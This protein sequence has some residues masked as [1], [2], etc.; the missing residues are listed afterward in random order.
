MC[1]ACLISRYRSHLN[2]RCKR[3]I[4]IWFCIYA[5]VVFP[6][7]VNKSISTGNALVV[8]LFITFQLVFTVFATCDHKRHDLKGSS[9]LAIG[10]SVCV[11]HLFAVSTRHYKQI[12]RERSRKTKRVQYRI[13]SSTTLLY[14]LLMRSCGCITTSLY[15]G[16][17]AFRETDVII[18]PKI[19]QTAVCSQHWILSP[20]AG[21]SL[22]HEW[23]RFS[24]LI[25]SGCTDNTF[26]RPSTVQVLTFGNLPIPSTDMI[27]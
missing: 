16:A 8:E 15:L 18:T 10:L 6:T 7:Q 14:L 3:A 19:Q 21:S 20:W 5:A 11:G 26:F 13:H 4:H 23:W 24:V 22:S 9:A 12:N 25:Y 2:T 1:S 17:V 27:T